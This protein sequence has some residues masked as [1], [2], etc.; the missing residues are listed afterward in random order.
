MNYSI[1]V[2]MNSGKSVDMELNDGIS[3][4]EA[5]VSCENSARSI[6]TGEGFYLN[7]DK[8]VSQN[9]HFPVSSVEFIQLVER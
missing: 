7:Y 1:R 6:L 2:H 4:G 9:F 5:S 3:L 8:M